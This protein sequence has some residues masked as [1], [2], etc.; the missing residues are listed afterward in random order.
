MEL[1]PHHITKIPRNWKSF[2]LPMKLEDF[3][4]KQYASWMKNFGSN[5]TVISNGEIALKDGTRAYRTDIEWIMKN[6]RP[7]ITNLVSAYKGG[8]CIY[9]VIHEFR[10]YKTVNSILQSLDV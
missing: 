2:F 1:L 9:I 5:I 3:G 8:K 4:P 7:V 6:N 10:S